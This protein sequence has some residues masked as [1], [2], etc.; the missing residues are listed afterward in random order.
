DNLPPL[1][2]AGILMAEAARNLVDYVN[3]LE[4]D[5]SELEAIEARR[6]SIHRLT[7]TYRRGVPELL[8]WRA[9]VEH[10][11]AA[12]GDAGGAGERAGA[13]LAGAEAECLKQARGLGAQR[14]RA[15]ATWGAR[16]TRELKPLGFA[17]ARLVFE[18]AQPRE[19][20]AG[21][22]PLGLD[23]VTMRFTANPG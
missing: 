12:G 17:S 19:E 21:F 9:E 8:A 6:D 13:R 20:V 2:E 10:E 11:L 23:A 14:A 7:Q 22:A 5:P 16:L 18:V 1:R 3:D 15:A 4:A